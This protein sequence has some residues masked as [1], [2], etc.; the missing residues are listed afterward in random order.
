MLC[1]YKYKLECFIYFIFFYFFIYM[2]FFINRFDI[3]STKKSYDALRLVNGADNYVYNEINN[4]GHLDVWWG[5][6]ANED[7]FPKVLDYLEETQHLWGYTA[8]QSRNGFHPF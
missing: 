5:T 7:V 3:K 4:Y 2:P 8:Q 6:N 1:K